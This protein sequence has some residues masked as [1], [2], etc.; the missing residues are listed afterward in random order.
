MSSDDDYL[1]YSDEDDDGMFE[2]EPTVNGLVTST[3]PT[4][5]QEYRVIASEHIL[6]EQHS[7][8]EE[9]KEML[10]ITDDIS[11]A[12]LR[13]FGWSKEKLIE[14]YYENTEKVVK[15]AG[16]VAALGKHKKTIPASPP[17]KTVQCKVCLE[18]FPFS[19]TEGLACGHRFCIDC[20]APYLKY[21]VLEGS[22]CIFT[23][24]PMN[25]CPEM[26]SQCTFKKI[27]DSESF[28]KYQKFL[29][30]SYV[31]INRNIKWCPNPQTCGKA[32]LGTGAADVVKCDCG[33]SFCFKCGEEA[34]F[35]VTCRQRS[36]WLDR[37][38]SQGGNAQWI[39]ENT[40]K[41]PKCM[42][43][44]EKN[45]GCNKVGCKQCGYN[46]CWICQGPWTEH[47]SGNYYGCNKYKKT[48]AGKENKVQSSTPAETD[49]F[50]HYYK[51]YMAHEEALK[52]ARKQIVRSMDVVTQLRSSGE[53]KKW[54]DNGD[55]YKDAARLV[56]DCRA[57]LKY[58]YVFAYGLEDG[59]PKDLFE[60]M[61]SNLESN[62]ES[63]T[64]MSEKDI[65]ALSRD[66]VINFVSVTRTL[67]AN[68][69]QGVE[70][71]LA[72][73]AYSRILRF[74]KPSSS[75]AN[76]QQTTLVA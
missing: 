39:L 31:D 54:I 47:G 68:L 9:V 53:A 51:R 63:L 61:Q 20:W 37:C 60:Y 70:T 4:E 36:E 14:K 76:K 59:N 27:L 71:G 29:I 26:V 15:D 62:V 74:S 48:S 52:F 10:G 12:L 67:Q 5:Q 72:S 22:T 69:L 65:Q 18:T 73:S 56:L 3:S 32:I 42:T 25:E 75:N 45:Q 30:D 33:T 1:G 34:H 41:C 58:T 17:T 8:I 64:E 50:L 19:H 16:V 49:R 35:P 55:F 6:T 23:T 11:A 66:E 43:R 28:S 7:I 38:D 24:C 57:V 21:K 2:E 40:K 13:N 44:I 46:F